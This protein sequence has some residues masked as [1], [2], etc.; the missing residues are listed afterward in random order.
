MN[1][2][3][4][5]ALLLATMPFSL[6]AK[7]TEQ[8]AADSLIS[9]TQVSNLRDVVVTGTRT[10][11]DIRHL[12]QTVTTVG[13]D[14]LTEM[15][16]PSV[17][18]TLTE[19]VPGLFITSRGVMGYGVSGGAAGGMNLRGIASGT[20]QLLVLIDGHPQYQGIFGH[21]IAD[22]YQ[23]LM[24][25]RVEVLRGPASMLYGSN[26]MGGVVNIVTR[27]MHTNGVHTE[28]ILGAG[29]YGTIQAEATNHVRSGRFSSTVS[30]QY[31]RSDNH[32]ANMGFEQ[33]GGFVKLGY[34]LTQHWNLYA[35][36]SL[37]HFNASNPGTLASPLNEA[38]Q[39]I[40]RGSATLA[41][42]N[43][44]ANTSGALSV[45]DNFGRHKINDGF[46]P[47]YNNNVPQTDLFR[48]K[49]AVA[50]V[51]WY[52]SARFFE[53]NRVTVGLD[54]Q[55]IYG[56]AYYT[57]RE[58]GEIVTTPR[59]LMQSA[60]A[61][62]NEVAA[63][64]DF[65][66]DITSW[67]TLDAGIRFD[68]HSTAGG[69]WI[70]QAG[71][72]VRPM[73]DATLK[74]S[75]SK[76]FRNPTNREMYIYGTA[77]HDSLYAERM[78]NYELSWRHR[79]CNGRF[80]YGINLYYLKADNLIQTVAGRNINTGELENKGIELEADWRIDRH[81][82]LNTNHSYL[83]ME[84]PMV[85]APTYKGYL[86]ARFSSG[87]W[88]ANAG[89]MQLCGLYTAVGADEVK[90]HATLLNASVG[91]QM[92]RNIGLWLRGENLLGQHY[93]VNLGYP[94]PKATF[95]AGVKVTL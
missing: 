60:H 36:A 45:Y 48:S 35:D 83:D 80:G 3:P 17:L 89:L 54:Y 79:L 19:Q 51:S 37:T 66:Q 65:R 46:G 1:T 5:V 61:H 10:P 31:Q 72:V 49:D 14:V 77:N 2:R 90:E 76:G 20:G 44:Y 94:M 47:K 52:Q 87:A 71:L 81:W 39:W 92:H 70:P 7:E 18:P 82:Q 50:G 85:A 55:H 59:R 53:G 73:S 26:A 64:A 22:A 12:S 67:L 75:V 8:A 25:E 41:I 56:R 15:E 93:E 38:D 33:Y 6:Q 95:M 84:N 62:E 30:G 91:W 9:P 40:T 42:E 28:A 24:T 88:T 86:G 34:D 43:H 4:L 74:L 58:T 68:H 69:E 78:M 11:A 23:T 16:R 21:S 57:N 13:R 27:G 29:S 63:Y 32:R